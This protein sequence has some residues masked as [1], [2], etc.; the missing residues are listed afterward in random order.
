MLSKWNKVLTVTMLFLTLIVSPMVVAAQG[1]SQQQNRPQQ[2]SNPPNSPN[3]SPRAE[4]C[5][6]GRNPRP[7]TPRRENPCNNGKG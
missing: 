1:K 4:E 7:G 2:A 5:A 3:A 6:R